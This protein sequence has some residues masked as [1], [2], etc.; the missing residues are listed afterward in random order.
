MKVQKM[1]EIELVQN[2][3]P[4]NKFGCYVQI[5]TLLLKIFLCYWLVNVII[6]KRISCR[7]HLFILS[8]VF[9][10]F[11]DKNFAT[12]N[13]LHSYMEM[14]N[15][16]CWQNFEITSFENMQCMDFFSR[17]SL[18]YLCIVFSI[19]AFFFFTTFEE[20]AYRVFDLYIVRTCMWL[21][22]VCRV[23]IR[24]K[25]VFY[26]TSSNYIHQRAHTIFAL[27]EFNYVLNMC[28]ARYA[29]VDDDDGEMVG[30]LSIFS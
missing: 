2:S 5:K 15:E 10:R 1:R 26:Q 9:S 7:I 25:N 28:E 11:D 13:K 20:Y 3:L 29:H 8:F 18:S 21:C 23:L 12:E 14:Q 30:V 27:Y 17:F 22:I 4:C 16:I 6:F 24:F 19:R